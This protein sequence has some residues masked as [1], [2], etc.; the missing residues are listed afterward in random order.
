MA[1]ASSW[2]QSPQ[3]RARL[4]AADGLEDG[5]Y[6]AGVQIELQPR[7]MTYWRMPG[8]GGLAPTFRFEGSR[9]LKTAQILY[10]APDR[11]RIKTEEAFGYRSEVA[12][13]LLVEPVDTTLPVHLVLTLDYA[14]CEDICIPAQAQMSCELRPASISTPAAATLQRWLAQVPKPFM[15]QTSLTRTGP[16]NWLI[17]TDATELIDIF[18]EGPEGWYFETKP[19]EGG[20]ALRLVAQVGAQSGPFPLRL[21]LVTAKGAFEASTHL[22]LS[23]STP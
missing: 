13:P 14:T 3:S 4:I 19:A 5:R 8:D 6:L 17:K 9:N 23:A 16:K 2:S 20:F 1:Q 11:Y 18:A 12:F 15:G 7:F 22:D 21:T 10:P